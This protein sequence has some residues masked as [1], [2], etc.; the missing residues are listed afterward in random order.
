VEGTYGYA[1]SLSDLV[2][3]D[4]LCH[5]LLNILDNFN[6]SVHHDCTPTQCPAHD[7]RLVSDTVCKIETPNPHSLKQCCVTA[8]MAVKSGPGEI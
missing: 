4:P 7:L 1:K 8:T 5:K 2:A 3:L 6:R